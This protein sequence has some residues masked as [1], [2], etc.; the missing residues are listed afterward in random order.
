[1]MR[2]R[3]GIAASHEVQDDTPAP[4]S[5]RLKAG[6]RLLR[7]DILIYRTQRT[8]DTMG[9]FSISGT[10]AMRPT[11]LKIALP[12][13]LSAIVLSGC[14]GLFFDYDT[15]D[16]S[17]SYAWNVQQHMA[18]A[19]QEDEMPEDPDW[20]KLDPEMLDS[21][22]AYYLSKNTGYAPQRKSLKKY[23]SESPEAAR[24]AEKI[25][26]AGYITNTLGGGIGES[27]VAAT[28]GAGMMIYGLFGDVGYIKP[29]MDGW[30]EDQTLVYV[31]TD[32]FSKGSDADRYIIDSYRKAAQK[33]NK[34]LIVKE[35]ATCDMISLSI[36]RPGEKEP[37]FYTEQQRFESLPS[38]NGTACN[39]PISRTPYDIPA[40]LNG[41]TP[42]RKA[43]TTRLH[44]N[45]IR[46][47]ER[48]QIAAIAK[49]LPDFFYIYIAPRKDEA[50]KEVVHP[51][52]IDNKGIHEF[53]APAS[54][55]QAVSGT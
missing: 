24:N 6:F 27:L 54:K 2:R 11:S 18:S 46:G 41:G 42:D 45:L 36:S 44:G 47:S 7:C 16:A 50:T 29:R 31:P 14:A 52:V 35:E 32:K 9:R 43:W 23:L 15:Y 1:M 20:A 48:Q 33:A 10:S 55:T 8:T 34:K 30:L 4:P 37:F 5:L 25:Y 3:C 38:V 26:G 39:N 49:Y 13:T 21:K 19:G 53:V 40:W 51:V 28:V 12:L 22:N 17:K